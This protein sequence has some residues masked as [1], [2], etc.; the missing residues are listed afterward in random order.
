MQ[1]YFVV[2]LEQSRTQ[3]VNKGGE[4]NKYTTVFNTKISCTNRIGAWHP[5]FPKTPFEFLDLFHA[6]SSRDRSPDL[7]L[8]LF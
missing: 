1:S 5:S 8:L 7:R 3:D 4:D 6:A 2:E